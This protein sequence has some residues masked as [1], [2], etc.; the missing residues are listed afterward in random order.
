M[1]TNH[2]LDWWLRWNG[3]CSLT[4]PWRSLIRQVYVFVW[5]GGAPG[6]GWAVLTHRRGGAPAFGVFPRAP[7][8]R[9]D[10]ADNSNIPALGARAVTLESL[11]STRQVV[12][13]SLL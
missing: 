3:R 4:V 1:V 6:P 10:R 8:R 11:A 7:G 13:L 12:C 5:L 2:F 9:H